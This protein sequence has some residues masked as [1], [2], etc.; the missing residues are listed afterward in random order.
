[1]NS[2][3]EEILT[4]L[5]TAPRK[6]ASPRPATTALNEVALKGE[7]LVA[8]FIR[9]VTAQTETVHRARNKHSVLTKLA[10]I[11]KRERIKTIMASDDDVMRTLDLAVWGKKNGIKVLTPLDFKD[12]GRYIKAVFD[13][14]QAGITGADFAVAESGTLGL[15]HNK[16]QPRLISLAPIHHI[17]IVPLDRLVP[18]YE[19]ITDNLYIKNKSAPCHVTFISG[20]SR[21]SDIKA[22]P[23]KGMHGPKKLE[24]ILTG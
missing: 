17:A 23:F 6:Q 12:R 15:I 9:E 2:A 4:K 20:P 14:A 24:I 21:S 22:T 7:E 8:K 3:R 13:E 19:N 10:A 16:E 18:V 1:M 5:K 11:F